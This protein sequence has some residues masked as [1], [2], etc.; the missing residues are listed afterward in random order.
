M[1]GDHGKASS[2]SYGGFNLFSSLTALS[3]LL[4]SYGGHELA[5]GFT[6]H[7]RNIDEFRRQ[8]T[9]MATGFYAESGPRTQLDI[10]CAIPPEMLTIRG[11]DALEAREPCGNG[12]PKPV[13][14]MEKLRI[15]R[16]S[17]VGSGRHMRLRLRAGRQT[18]NAIYF[19]ATP[20]TA[21][22]E[23]GD[24][25]D[26]AF[27]PQVNEF[28][29]ER[30]VQMNVLDIRPSCAVPCSGD[31]SGF[32]A[33]RR[34][35]VTPAIAGEILPDRAALA[36]VW[37]YLAAAP[38]PIQE[39]PVCL[40]RKIVRW[41][42]VSLDLSKLLV[43]L[44]VFRDVGLLQ[45]HRQHKHITISLTPGSGKADLNQSRTMQTLLHAKES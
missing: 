3:G 22:I 31:D 16:L 17:M 44:E 39:S 13:L 37:R 45:I 10:D 35:T 20:E 15:D 2:R 19:S 28:R 26:I 8:I 32:L 25:V 18:F 23:P 11:I 29:G 27:N 6:I 33:L 12:C 5:A 43:C 7:R 34:G 14:M 36:M 21:S 41:S 30:S 24:L 40:C 42:G 38:A 4:E 1:D 9:R